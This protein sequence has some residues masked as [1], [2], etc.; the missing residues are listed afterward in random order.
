PRSQF[1]AGRAIRGGVPVIFPWFGPRADAPSAPEHGFARVAEWFVESVGRSDD[2]SVAVVLGLDATDATRATWPHAFHLRHRVVVG[3]HVEMEF[4]V[5]N[6]S[7]S[8]LTFEEALHTYLLVGDV[9]EVTVLGLE[10][11][12]YIDKMDGM[13]RK[14]HDDAGLRPG[15]PIDRVFVD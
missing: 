6:R 3:K 2:G 8:S 7:R 5:E 1:V 13:K 10:G 15:G 12:T 9:R 11:V 14:V 4:E